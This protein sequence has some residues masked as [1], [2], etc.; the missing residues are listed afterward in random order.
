MFKIAVDIQGFENEPMHAINACYD[1]VKKYNNVILYLVGLKQNFTNYSETNNIKFAYCEN[2]FTQNDSFLAIRSKQNTSLEECCKLVNNNIVDAIVSACNTSVFV[3]FLYMNIGLIKGIKK[4]AFMPTI[5]KVEGCFR[6]LDVG[7][8]L[9]VEPIDLVNFALMA[10]HYVQIFKSDPVIKLL[11][12]GTEE[13]K[14][15]LLQV[16]ANKLLKSKTNLNYHGFIESNNLFTS[17]ADIV[18]CD[19]VIGNIALK[20]LEGTAKTIGSELKKEF[21]K[22]SN[23][24]KGLIVRKNLKAVANKFDYKKN[25][26]AIVLGLNKV[27]IKTHGSA[28]YEQFYSSLEMA[29]KCLENNLIDNIKGSINER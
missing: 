22:K 2:F 11:N 8:S 7:A 25:A 20:A 10:N 14:G 23:L 24:L 13:H 6:M 1:F 16:E 18:V 3:S 17:D 15:P 19:A 26:G 28:D 5:P 27:A 21:T 29:V 12:I 4:L 9:D